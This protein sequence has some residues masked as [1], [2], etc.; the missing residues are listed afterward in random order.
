MHTRIIAWYNYALLAIT[1]FTI[2][3][4]FLTLISL[5]ILVAW[6]LPFSYLTPFGTLLFTP[7]LTLY[8]WCALVVFLTTLCCIPNSYCIY[9]LECVSRWWLWAL[10]LISQPWQIGFVKPPLLVLCA[11]PFSAFLLMLF[12]RHQRSVII[13]ISLSVLLTSWLTALYMIPSLPVL[14]VSSDRG[15]SV[16]VFYD[17]GITTV[18]DVDG[19]CNKAGDGCSLILHKIMPEITKLMGAA[20]ID[21]FVVLH[22]RQRVFEALTALCKKHVVHDVYVPR[23]SGRIPFNAWSAYKELQKTLSEYGYTIRYLKCNVPFAVH[24]TAQLHA[25]D[26]QQKY[27]D[28]TYQQFTLIN[29]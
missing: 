28:A 22:P 17:A 15:K 2:I 19:S 27:G 18:I 7:V 16:Q 21:R 1:Q 13:V 14:T 29:T 8:L 26:T 5:P 3:Q 25:T 20:H 4:L 11:I 10:S 23:W 24:K 9:A 12:V 6:G